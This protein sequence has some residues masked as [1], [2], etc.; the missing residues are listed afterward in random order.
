M[1]RKQIIKKSMTRKKVNKQVPISFSEGDE[2][3]IRILD[4]KLE[5][6]S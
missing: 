2:E 6:E 3:L 5:K 1:S 4:H